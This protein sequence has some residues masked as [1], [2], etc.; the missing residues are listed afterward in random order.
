[1]LNY[2][3]FHWLF[4][5]LDYKFISPSKTTST[6]ATTA[7]FENP[8]KPFEGTDR[9]ENT[10]S[11]SSARY[12]TWRNR[13]MHVNM[14]LLR[15]EVNY[16]YTL[17]F[18]IFLSKPISLN[19]TFSFASSNTCVFDHASVINRHKLYAR[20]NQ[21]LHPNHK[22]TSTWSRIPWK[23]YTRNRNKCK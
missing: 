4:I 11:S 1:M 5:V 15:H 6:I 14:D 16:F 18:Q 22:W 2:L 21:Q 7:P 3:I 8:P 20:T 10:S 17:A 23:W 19:P 13:L 12:W 9:W